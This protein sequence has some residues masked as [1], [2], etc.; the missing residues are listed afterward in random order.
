[1]KTI[2]LP[3]EVLDAIRWSVSA[4]YKRLLSKEDNGWRP[5]WIEIGPIRF[6]PERI[7]SE[8]K[9]TLLDTTNYQDVLGR[10]ADL[11]ATADDV[12]GIISHLYTRLHNMESDYVAYTKKRLSALEQAFESNLTV[13][14]GERI[15]ML[16][17][18]RNLEFR[19]FHDKDPERPSGTLLQDGKTVQLPENWGKL[20]CPKCHKYVALGEPCDCS[21]SAKPKCKT[22][23][24]KVTVEKPW[25]EQ[26]IQPCHD[27]SNES[28]R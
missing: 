19:V 5:Q 25:E 8:D 26:W 12:V 17:R 22:C 28:E 18:L 13:E 15:D 1:M 21:Q 7:S 14:N 3:Q 6:V 27:C 9:S 16:E 20:E 24:D 23:G 11:D 10:V 4:Q 2:E